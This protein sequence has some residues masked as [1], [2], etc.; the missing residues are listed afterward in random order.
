MS[1]GSNQQ[2]PSEVEEGQSQYC[3]DALRARDYSSEGSDEHKYRHI[4]PDAQRG[5]DGVRVHPGNV[6]QS[7]DVPGI[8]APTDPS[9]SRPR[10]QLR[11]VEKR[12]VTCDLGNE[13]CEMPGGGWNKKHARSPGRGTSH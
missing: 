13:G 10:H 2:L 6:A 3:N 11:H 4:N 9:G 7:V 5:Y 8:A 1:L 12:L